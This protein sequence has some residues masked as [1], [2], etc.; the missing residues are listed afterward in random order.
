MRF[1]DSCAYLME[2]FVAFKQVN[3]VEEFTNKYE[4]F[5]SLL[6][7]SHPYLTEQY[8]LEN[9]I[10]ILKQNLKCF[11]RTAKPATLVNVVWFARQFEK[12]LKFAEP[13]NL[14]TSSD[15]VQSSQP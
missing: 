1:G 9:Y 6:L 3:G 12:G 4:E 8:F 10:A 7:Q 2:E 5:R 14:Y 15:V 11:V 13:Q